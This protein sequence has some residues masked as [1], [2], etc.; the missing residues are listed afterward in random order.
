MLSR[1]PTDVSTSLPQ[2]MPLS[3]LRETT[4]LPHSA[5]L[6]TH[7]K[8]LKTNWPTLTLPFLLFALK[9]NRDSAR[10]MR[11]SKLS[12]EITGLKKSG[13]SPPDRSELNH[14]KK[15]KISNFCFRH[16]HIWHMCTVYLICPKIE[17]MLSHTA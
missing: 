12:G 6:K 1:T 3:Q 7:S 16:G 15:S 17:I 9:W 4:W 13:H 5:T 10:R 8:T 14:V 2:P 11:R